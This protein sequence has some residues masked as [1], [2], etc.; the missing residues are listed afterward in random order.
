MTRRINSQTGVQ[1]LSSKYLRV[2]LPADTWVA[3]AVPAKVDVM[4]AISSTIVVVRAAKSAVLPAAAPA[5][6][7]SLL[8]ETFEL[9]ARYYAPAFV[10][11]GRCGGRGIHQCVYRIKSSNAIF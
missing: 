8:P 9:R 1:Q 11:L 4:E 5:G 3:V 10:R 6:E 7:G 2:V